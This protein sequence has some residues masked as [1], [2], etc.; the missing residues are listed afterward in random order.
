[1]NRINEV[2][3]KNNVIGFSLSTIKNFEINKLSCFGTKEGSVEVDEKTMFSACSISKLITTILVLIAKDEGLISLNEDINK[4]LKNWKLKSNINGEVAAI[5]D[6]LTYQSG[7]VDADNSYDVYDLKTGRCNVHDLIK[8]KTIYIKEEISINRIPKS[9]FIYS[10]NNFLLLE[11]LLEDLYGKPFRELAK[12]KIFD[13]L[14]MANSQYI[15]YENLRSYDIALGHDKDGIK[16]EKHKN[17]YPYDSVA[18]LWTTSLDL[19]KLLIELLRGYKQEENK[20]LKNETVKAMMTAHGCVD[21]TGYGV[22][23]YKL[24]GKEVF[25][26]QGWGEGFQSYMLGFL[27]DGE[28]IIVMMNQNP[29]VEQME[30]PIGEIVKDY[31]DEKFS[32]IN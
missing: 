8:G 31:I 20:L 4:H 21:F 18:G 11:K 25:Y 30:G 32:V 12:E 19:S 3:T 2:L 1:M 29:G 10:D 9:D 28:G 17:I 22:F 23:V 7:I 24:R 5:E 16:I 14:E 15:D 6:L 27:E 13:P 26:T